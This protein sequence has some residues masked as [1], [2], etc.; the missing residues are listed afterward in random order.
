MVR[1]WDKAENRMER[2]GAMFGTDAAAETA[3]SS[4]TL[5]VLVCLALRR[6]AKGP[7]SDLAHIRRTGEVID[8]AERAAKLERRASGNASHLHNGGP[9]RSPQGDLL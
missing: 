3:P 9:L 2:G 7:R 5:T 6:Q 1:E 4:A 8:L